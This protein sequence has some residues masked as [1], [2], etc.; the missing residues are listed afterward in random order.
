MNSLNDIIKRCAA[1]S[2]LHTVMYAR[3]GEA[4]VRMEEVT[5]YPVLLRLFNERIAE[6][7]IRMRRS[8]RTTLYFGDALGEVEPDTEMTVAPVVEKMEQRAFDFI[9]SLRKAGIEVSLVSNMT[10]FVGKFDAL[11]AGVKCDLTLT[12]NIC[13]G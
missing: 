3:M 6:T 5:Q 11:I 13:A 10:P 4:N 8:R 12:Y 9:A 1:D 2:G 7:N